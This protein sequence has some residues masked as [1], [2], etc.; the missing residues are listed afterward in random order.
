MKIIGTKMRLK[1][2]CVLNALQK[3]RIDGAF[4]FGGGG[5][6]GLGF[7]ESEESLG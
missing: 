6:S 2:G 4:F 5:V 7:G 3:S 1:E